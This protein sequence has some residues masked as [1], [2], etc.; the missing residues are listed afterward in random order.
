M[1]RDLSTF[2]Q[3]AAA[4]E[5]DAATVLD[6]SWSLGVDDAFVFKVRCDDQME[7]VL[8]DDL[9]AE[10]SWPAEAWAPHLLEST[11]EEDAAEALATEFLE[12]LRLWN[13]GWTSCSKHQQLIFVCSAVWICPG[14]A[15]HEIA[16]V[17]TLSRRTSI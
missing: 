3:W 5:H 12:V 10:D 7:D 6:G 1:Q 15:T 4:L 14:P 11:L 17:G 8:L 16:L 13:V 2:R 9:V